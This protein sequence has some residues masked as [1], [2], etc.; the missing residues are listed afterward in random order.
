MAAEGSTVLGKSIIVR[1]ELT[2]SADLTI[3]GKLEGSIHLKES[4]L[5]IGPNA[6]LRADMNVHDAVILGRCEGNVLA[7]GRV[8]IRKGGALLGDIT[9]AT[10][11]IEDGANIRGKVALSGGKE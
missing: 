6:E 1:G 10:L 4:R 11:S 2:G 3:D 7:S 9:A 8:D 5:T